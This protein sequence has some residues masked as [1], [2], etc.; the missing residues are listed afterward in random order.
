LTGHLRPGTATF[1]GAKANRKLMVDQRLRP[2]PDGNVEI[3][4]RFWTFDGETR[5]QVPGLLVYADLLAIGDARCMET[6]GE[7][8]DGIV[9]RF[10]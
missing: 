8:Y 2:D 3:L 1:Y 7:M 4:R 9:T 5:G 10:E 6:A